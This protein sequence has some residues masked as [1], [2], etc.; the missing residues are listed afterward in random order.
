[1]AKLMKASA[2]GKRE[3]VPGSVPDNRT[4]KRWVENGLL[5]GRIVDGMVW[6]CASEHWGVD[7]M[8]S[9]NVRRLIQED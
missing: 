7:S 4:I 3:F 1:M 2:W 9:E 6:V 8:I 5:R